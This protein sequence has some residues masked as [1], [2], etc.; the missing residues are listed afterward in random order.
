MKN[1]TNTKP[2][3][4]YCGGTKATVT[5][6]YGDTIC[7][8]CFVVDIS[9]RKSKTNATCDYC[10]GPDATVTTDYG[11][12]ICVPCFIGKPVVVELNI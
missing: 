7:D 3:C 5:T 11:D 6:D 12:T 10:A 9:E 2:T 8:F 1:N 4:L